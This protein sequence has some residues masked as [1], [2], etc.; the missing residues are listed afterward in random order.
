MTKCLKM[1]LPLVLTILS[2]I[3]IFGLTFQNPK[4]SQEL[5]VVVQKKIFV[6]ADIK[7]N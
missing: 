3:V 6:E 5:S 7:K 2:I 1:W 4:A